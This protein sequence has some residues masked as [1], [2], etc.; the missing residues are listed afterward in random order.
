MDVDLSHNPEEITN[1]IKGLN[2]SDV[3]PGSRYVPMGRIDTWGLGRVVIS[4]TGNL[5]TRKL[6]HTTNLKEHSY[7]P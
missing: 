3:V 2:D 6:H 7:F 1:F 5:I 4:R